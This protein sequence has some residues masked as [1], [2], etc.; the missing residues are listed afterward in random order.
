MKIH[1]RR[2][3]IFLT[4]II[5]F[6]SFLALNA[7][8]KPSNCIY[9]YILEAKEGQFTIS[10]LSN[11]TIAVPFNTTATA[12]VTLKVPAGSFQVANL[13]NL[14]EGVVFNE[15]G[16]SNAPEEASDYDYIVFG[17]ASLGTRNILYTEGEKIPLFSF[18][19][20]GACTNEAV[21]LMDNIED[22]FL[23]PN[24]ERANVGQQITVAKTGSDLAIICIE[25][26]RVSDCGEKLK[27]DK[28]LKKSE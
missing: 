10:I 5:F 3:P 26:N 14:I 6:C 13:K 20:S 22:P 23:P 8:N 21:V 27:K 18:E 11:Q 4:S 24:S 1:V 2:F 15:N 25:N 9:T 19:N 16:R 17:L 7:Q 12:Q 28:K